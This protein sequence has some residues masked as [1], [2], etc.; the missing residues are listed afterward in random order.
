VDKAPFRA[1]LTKAGFYG[2]W[3]QKFGPELWA[4]L[5]AATGQLS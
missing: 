5:E 4:A 2:D 1:A 3:K